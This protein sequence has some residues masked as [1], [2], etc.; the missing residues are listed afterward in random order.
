MMLISMSLRHTPPSV[1][2][3]EKRRSFTPER[4][5]RP[6]DRPGWVRRSV[7]ADRSYA[8]CYWAHAS[9]RRVRRRGCDASVVGVVDVDAGQLV[10][11]RLAG[12]LCVLRPLS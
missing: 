7:T 6:L 11:M 4:G 3:P 10:V 8:H 5:A 12:S 2:I 9:E 1:W